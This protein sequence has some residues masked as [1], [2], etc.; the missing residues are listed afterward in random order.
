MYLLRYN[1][2]F[3]F[4]IAPKYVENRPNRM[5]HDTIITLENREILETRQI[6]SDGTNIWKLLGKYQIYIFDTGYFI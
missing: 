2:S 3:I 6:I 4:K 1:R 5:N